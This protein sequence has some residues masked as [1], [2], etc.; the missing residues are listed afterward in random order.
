MNVRECNSLSKIIRKIVDS[1]KWKT[2]NIFGKESAVLELTREEVDLLERLLMHAEVKTEYRINGATLERSQKFNLRWLIGT[3]ADGEQV[4]W[5]MEQDAEDIVNLIN[6]WNSVIIG[7]YRHF[8]LLSQEE[9][10]HERW[11]QSD[12]DNGSGSEASDRD[13][14]G[15]KDSWNRHRR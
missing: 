8:K 1:D 15:S 2:I 13:I 7:G 6:L 9:I 14:S 5:L 4:I 3:R 10:E 11:R 12:S